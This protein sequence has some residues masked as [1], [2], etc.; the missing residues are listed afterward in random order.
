TPGQ[1]AS[2]RAELTVL[3]AA[4]I[5]GT[6]IAAAVPETL[7]ADLLRSLGLHGAPVAVAVALL[8][9][10]FAQL[11]LN[12]IVTATIALTSLSQPEVF[13]LEPKLLALAVMT[14]WMLAVG[15]SPMTTSVLITARV[16]E[17]SPYTVGYRWNGWFTLGT[18]ALASVWLLVL[19]WLIGPS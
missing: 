1:L 17:A 9:L 18:A 8:M 16:A 7:L 11:G 13:G 3:A 12:P 15:S 6:M 14:G 2:L 19:G 5:L 10:V 4:G